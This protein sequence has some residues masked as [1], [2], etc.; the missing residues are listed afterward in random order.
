MMLFRRRIDLGL[1]PL[2]LREYASAE[3]VAVDDVREVDVGG[4]VLRDFLL[5]S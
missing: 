5:A 3:D 4:L 2:L 1:D